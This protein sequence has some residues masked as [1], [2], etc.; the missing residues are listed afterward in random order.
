MAAKTSACHSRRHSGRG[1]RSPPLGS[2]PG[3]QKP[4]GT[5]ANLRHVEWRNLGINFVM[6]FSPGTFRGA[7]HSDLA[8]LTLPEGPDPALEARI[9]RDAAKEFPSVS[10]VRVKDTLDAVNDLVGKLVFAIR[11]ASAVAV[12]TSLFVL[13]GALAA[14]HRA[15]LY[16][17]VVLKTLGATRARLLAAYTMEY[18]ALGLATAVFGLVA[19][20]LAGWVILTKVMRLDFALDLSGALLAAVLAVVVAVGLGLAGTWRILSQKPAQYLR[21]L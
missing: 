8:T 5:I 1:G 14:G 9:L 18:G 20:T 2:V 16:D 4:M 10:S 13:A 15:R 6:V 3:K 21:N 11:G 19:G 17:A 12:A 7:P